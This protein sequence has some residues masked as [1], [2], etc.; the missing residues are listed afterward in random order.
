MPKN[1]EE[2]P[3]IEA[4][5]NHALKMPDGNAWALATAKVKTPMEFKLESFRWIQNR[6]EELRK[7]TKLVEAIPNDL[8]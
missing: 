2:H 1:W 4:V 8:K 7:L 6:I 3:S 5:L